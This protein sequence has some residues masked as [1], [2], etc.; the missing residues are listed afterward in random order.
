MIPPSCEAIRSLLT[1]ALPRMT[2]PMAI[3]LVAG[4]LVT[5]KIGSV[6]PAFNLTADQHIDERA[7]DVAYHAIFADFSDH[8]GLGS[9][10]KY[11]LT[12]AFHSLQQSL[13]HSKP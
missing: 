4:Y 2:S 5:G 10:H 3:E 7:W 8:D 9:Y 11:S 13:L 12:Q 1:A 6:D